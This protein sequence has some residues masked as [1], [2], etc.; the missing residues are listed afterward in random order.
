MDSEKALQLGRVGLQYAVI[1]GDACIIHKRVDAAEFFQRLAGHLLPLR[2]LA[3]SCFTKI[4]SSPSS[5]AKAWPVSSA[6]S[7]S[8]SL[9]PASLNNLASAAPWPRAGTGDDHD[10]S[11]HQHASAPFI[12]HDLSMRKSCMQQGKARQRSIAYKISP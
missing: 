8:T 5:F 11:L 12:G 4:A 9:A 2:S 6:R 3:T 10:F 7:V 1:A